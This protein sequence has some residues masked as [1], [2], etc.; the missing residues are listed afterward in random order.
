MRNGKAREDPETDDDVELVAGGS[1]VDSNKE[2]SDN[3]AVSRPSPTLTASDEAP[4]PICNA[5]MPIAAI[6]SHIDRGCPPPKAKAGSSGNQKQDWKK[7][8]SGAGSS[9]AKVV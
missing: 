6:S 9:K 2:L 1:D 5:R 3:G 8:F 4:C 7:L